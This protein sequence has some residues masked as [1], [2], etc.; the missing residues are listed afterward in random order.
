MSANRVSFST[1]QLEAETCA[2][3]DQFLVAICELVRQA[4]LDAVVRRCGLRLIGA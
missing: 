4:A 2:R 1:T 3:I